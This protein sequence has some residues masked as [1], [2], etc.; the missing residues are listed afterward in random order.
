[1]FEFTQHTSEK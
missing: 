1:M